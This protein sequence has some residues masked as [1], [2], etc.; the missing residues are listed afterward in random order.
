MRN[1]TCTGTAAA[2]LG[3]EAGRQCVR[4]ELENM[5]MSRVDAQEETDSQSCVCLSELTALTRAQNQLLCDI[6]GAVNALTA[7]QLA[8]SQRKDS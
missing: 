3:Y 6:L 7:A 1:R 2:S 4:R 8:A 5:P